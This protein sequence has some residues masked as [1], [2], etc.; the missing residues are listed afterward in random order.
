[1]VTDLNLGIRVEIL[2]P[3]SHLEEL[4]CGIRKK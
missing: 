1:M 3:V 2:S 4:H